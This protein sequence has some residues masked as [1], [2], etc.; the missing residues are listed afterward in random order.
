[1][2]TKSVKSA[3]KVTVGAVNRTV[4]L[5][6][7]KWASVKQVYR[8]FKAMDLAAYKS[9]G[10]F[11]TCALRTGDVRKLD[12][13][14][15]HIGKDFV[16]IACD[17]GIASICGTIEKLDGKRAICSGHFAL[18]LDSQNVIYAGSFKGMLDYIKKH[19]EADGALRNGLQFNHALGS[20]AHYGIALVGKGNKVTRLESGTCKRGASWFYSLGA[21]NDGSQ[22]DGE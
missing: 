11:T 20:G 7:G 16:L 9:Q 2:A 13:A 14:R 22:D 12:K 18:A 4:E 6:V 3:V 19:G 17:Y 5:T 21:D 15:A 8:A 1:M 10:E